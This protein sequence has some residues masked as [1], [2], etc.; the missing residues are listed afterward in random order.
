MAMTM[1]VFGQTPGVSVFVDPIA[2]DLRLS[3][4]EISTLYS[5]ATLVAAIF[6]A[7]AGR[8]IDRHG[9]RRATLVIAV[10]FGLV[11]IGLA[12]AQ[13]LVWLAVGFFGIRLLGQGALSLAARTI[14]AIRFRSA[15]GRAV[16]I[17]GVT[18]AIGISLGPLALAGI[19]DRLGW[20]ETL[21]L[22]GISVWLVVIPLTLWLLRPGDDRPDSRA[23][24]R[25][26]SLDGWTREDA[27]RT[28]I[29][30][31]ITL[32]GAAVAGI[33]TGLTFHQ[34]SILG[35]AGLSA[36]QAAA[37]FVPQTVASVVAVGVVGPL[38]DRFSGRLL[39]AASMGLL[40]IGVA[41]VMVLALPWVPLLYALA[42][43][44]S[45]GATQ[46]LEGTLYP[47]YFGIRAIGAIR[48]TAFS[49]SIAGAAAGPI[50]VG[51][52]REATGSYAALTP[53]LL[54]VPLAMAAAGLRGA[55]TRATTS[56]GPR[57]RGG[58]RRLSVAPRSGPGVIPSRPRA[59]RRCMT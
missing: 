23:A 53:L 4:P 51:L 9:V 16:G 21:V 1:T 50:L 49:V 24:A 32:A 13:G 52:V 46:A 22:A 47:R 5:L 12:L 35:E 8:R 58:A 28:P 27:L 48:G 19:I 10:A 6:M 40:A 54:A 42:L 37:N 36:G 45:L 34:I 59:Q 43:G 14:L 29:F 56:R 18:A 7:R 11:I 30:W 3:R 57:Q 44:A 2:Q 17:T 15:L 20:R 55:A 25:D 31:L 33:L 39:L 26:G 38:A 41:L